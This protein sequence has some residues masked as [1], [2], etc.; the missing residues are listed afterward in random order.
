[1]GLGEAD[2]AIMSPVTVVKRY[3]YRGWS[4]KRVGLKCIPHGLNN[5]RRIWQI[6]EEMR[7]NDVRV[8]H[9]PYSDDEDENPT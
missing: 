1:M 5:R 2:S 3:Y 9:N 6:L 8:L 7:P 4:Y